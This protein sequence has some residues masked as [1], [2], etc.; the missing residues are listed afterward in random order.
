MMRSCKQIRSLVVYVTLI[1]QALEHTLISSKHGLVNY[2]NEYGK[3]TE[4]M[5]STY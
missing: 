2:K 1:L 4:D 3:L 5:Y